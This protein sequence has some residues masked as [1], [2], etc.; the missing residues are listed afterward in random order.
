MA[1]YC[2]NGEMEQALAAAISSLEQDGRPGLSEQLSVTWIRYGQSPRHGSGG[3]GQGTHW[4]GNQ[5]RYP[6]SV[7]KL[8]YL[9]AAEAWLQL[10]LIH[11]SEPTRPY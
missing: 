11:I 2:P 7:V 4:R 8:L 5:A 9:L 3:E 10:S 6:A 1:F